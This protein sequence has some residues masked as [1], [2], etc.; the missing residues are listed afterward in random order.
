MK[1]MK[2]FLVFFEMRVKGIYFLKTVIYLSVPSRGPDSVIAYAS[3][4]TSLVVKWSHLPDEHFQGQPIGYYII[5]FPADSESDINF[6]NV[7]FTSNSTIVSNLTVYTIYV[8]NV[9]AVSAGGIGPAHTA[10]ARTQAEGNIFFKTVK[11]HF[12]STASSDTNYNHKWTSSK[13]KY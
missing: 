8:I 3:N 7:N 12:S 10:R 11:F 13:Q 2:W 5:Y 6:V 1:N 9:S 4:S